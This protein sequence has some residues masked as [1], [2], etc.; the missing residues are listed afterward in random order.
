MFNGSFSDINTLYCGI[1]H[2]SSLDPLLYNIFANEDINAQK[3]TCADD[4]TFYIDAVSSD[5]LNCIFQQEF[6]V[7]SNWAIE[8]KSKVNTLKKIN[9]KNV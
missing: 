3:V 7:I 8:N 5:S 6:N 1:P 4:T 9:K 2:G